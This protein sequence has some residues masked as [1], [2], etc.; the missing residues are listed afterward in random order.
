VAFPSTVRIF[1]VYLK[2]IKRKNKA[3]TFELQHK[4]VLC[5]QT[6]AHTHTH[7]HTHTHLHTHTNK[8]T[9]KQH[10]T[11]KIKQLHFSCIQLMALL[12]EDNEKKF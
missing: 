10:E 9:N 6:H 2:C 11:Q 1:Q 3:F 4:H 5:A 7:M 8:Q 12:A